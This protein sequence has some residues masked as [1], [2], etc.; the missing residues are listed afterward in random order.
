[1]VKPQV[2]A[3]SSHAIS[4]N[5]GRHQRAPSTDVY[6]LFMNRQSWMTPTREYTVRAADIPGQSGAFYD[7]TYF[8][9]Y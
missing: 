3:G 8:P 2:T 1:M 7:P 6:S 9:T 4:E 5:S